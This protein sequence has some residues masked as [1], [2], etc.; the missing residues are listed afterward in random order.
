M[1]ISQ[2]SCECGPPLSLPKPGSSH[3]SAR[4][5]QINVPPFIPLSRKPTVRPR[6]NKGKARIVNSCPVFHSLPEA[7]IMTKK[8][9]LR[10]TQESSLQLPTKWLDKRDSFSVSRP[11]DPAR[12]RHRWGIEDRTRGADAVVSKGRPFLGLLGLFSSALPPPYLRMYFHESSSLVRVI[13]CLRR[14]DRAPG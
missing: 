5:G 1:A 9:T 11:L 8:G 2:K 10:A 7:A 6:K 13:L 14:R 12:C 3:R 4:S